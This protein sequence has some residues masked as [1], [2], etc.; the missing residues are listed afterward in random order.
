MSRPLKISTGSL[1]STGDVLRSDGARIAVHVARVPDGS[2]SQ[3][4]RLSPSIFPSTCRSLSPRSNCG[5]I[6]KLN[7]SPVTSTFEMGRA[8]P[9]VPTKRP[10]SVRGPEG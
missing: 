10:T 4:A 9:A 2:V 5:G 8:L 1:H 6:E 7:V 3:P